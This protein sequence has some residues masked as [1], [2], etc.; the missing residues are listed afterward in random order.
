V[1][2]IS[3][4][5]GYCAAVVARRATCAGLGLDVEEWGRVGAA[6]W[7]QIAT[8]PEIAWLRAQAEEAARWAT[9]LFSAKEAFYKAQF[10]VSRCFLGFA[11]AAFH[12]RAPGGFEIELLREVPGVGRAGD[13]F[14]GRYATC[15]R[16]C[17]T[18]IHL[19]A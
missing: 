6:L 2:S 13:R 10:A 12:A 5:W 4:A 11:G 17:Y 7:R 15:A 19:R 14:A 18:G 1:G 16:R 9:I 3:H 8:P